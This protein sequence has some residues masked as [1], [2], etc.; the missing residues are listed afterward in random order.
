DS[1]AMRRAAIP[2]GPQNRSIS[3]SANS[4]RSV[5]TSPLS[6]SAMGANL[7]ATAS[8]SRSAL[9][10]QRR[11]SEALPTPAVRATASMLNPDQPDR[12]KTRRAAAMMRRSTSG[13]RG[14]PPRSLDEDMFM[15]SRL[16]HLAGVDLLNSYR[17]LSGLY[18]ASVQ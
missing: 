4:T 5:R 16:A 10:V 14:R 3:R 17:S 7:L 11:Y 18:T 2:S 13:S 1:T 12:P 6:I 8:V 9:L 15:G